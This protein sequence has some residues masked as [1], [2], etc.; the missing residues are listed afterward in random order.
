MMKDGFAF[1]RLGAS[2][3]RPFAS[4]MLKLAP[5]AALLAAGQPKPTTLRS[6]THGRLPTP[7]S[8]ATPCLG[9]W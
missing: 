2:L 8:G 5:L 6:P 9:W 4:A 1:L 3:A 7:R